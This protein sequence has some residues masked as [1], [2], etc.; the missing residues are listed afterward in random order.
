MGRIL[1]IDY[2]TKRTGIAVSDPL[3]L[4]ATP[5]DIVASHRLEDFLEDYLKKEKIDKVIVGNPIDMQGKKT[6]TSRLVQAFINRFRK[7]FVHIPLHLHDERY[8]SKIAQQAMIAGGMKKK[9]RRN[10][11]NIDKISATLILQSYMESVRK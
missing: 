10:K 3:Q 8:T 9:N 1:A 11:G 6:E 5:L 2:G 7:I 4:I